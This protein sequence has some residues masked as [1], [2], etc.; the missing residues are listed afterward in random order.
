MKKQRITSSSVKEPA[1]G[2]WSNCVKLGEQVFISG[3]TARADD[4]QT[5]L[6]KDEYEQS[7]VIFEK[8]KSLMGAA[9]GKMDDV[10]KMTIFVT[11]ISN[12]D[13]VWQARREFFSGDFPAC[14]LVEVSAL[15]KAEIFV[16]IEAVGFVGCS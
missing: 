16:E 15:A 7:R 12:N 14:S 3:L 10:V 9:G 1:P 8:M 11:D 5:I 4:G 6:G 13:K 2:L